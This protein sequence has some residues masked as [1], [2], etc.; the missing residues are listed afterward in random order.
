MI[1]RDG[2]WTLYDCNIKLGRQVW[3]RDNPDG[4]RTFRTD[5]SVQ[6]TLDLNTAQRNM[7]AK[8]WAGD[9]HMIASVPLNV[10]HDALV[11]A[12]SQ[13]DDAYVSRWLNDGDNSKFRTKE[14]RV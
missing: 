3:V 5:Y 13:G 12:H 4:S 14:G 2:D 9:Y 11:E 1:V 6:P 7:T 10:A 8:G